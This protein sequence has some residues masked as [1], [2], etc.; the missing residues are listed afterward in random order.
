MYD[1]ERDLEQG[2]FAS[3]EPV[4]YIIRPGDRLTLAV[5][6]NK[7][8]N[9][10]NTMVA[11]FT[12]SGSGKAMEFTVNQDGQVFLPV[13]GFYA[14]AGMTLSDAETALAKL[15]DEKGFTDP[16]VAMDVLNREVFVHIGTSASVVPLA[17][18]S[19]TVIEVL[20]MAGGMSTDGNASRV[21]LIR[22]IDGQRQ[23]QVL[24][25]S[26]EQALTNGE[27]VVHPDDIIYVKPVRPLLVALSQVT[28]YVAVVT[29]LI[30]TY[31][32]YRALIQ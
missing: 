14:I 3:P 20:T 8:Y 9:Q 2:T 7:A 31:L 32:A 5:F 29:G 18:E 10:V 4:E 1:V 22:K 23:V 13:I 19:V 6:T 11:S 15:Y 28:S 21:M 12:G 27:L 17:D 26:D 30:T 24:D 25:M 16:L